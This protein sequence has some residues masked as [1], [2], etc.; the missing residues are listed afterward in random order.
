MRIIGVDFSGAGT[1]NHVGNTWLAQGR[2]EG[3]TLT[4]ESC[5][6]I[7]RLA[8]T[9]ELAGLT[10]PAVVGMDFPFSVPV[11]FA[12]HW[13]REIDTDFGTMPDLWAAA[14]GIGK[15]RKFKKMRKRFTKD[16]KAGEKEPKRPCD[17]SEGISPLNIRMRAMTLAG[18]QMLHRLWHRYEAG[19]INRPL[20]ILP[21]HPDPEPDSI[22]LLE[23]MPGASVRSLVGEAHRT[24]YKGKG[25]WSQWRL[26]ILDELPEQV[27]KWGLR[28]SGVSER[29]ELCLGNDDAMDAI[30]AAVT[31]ALWKIRVPAEKDSSKCPRASLVG[32]MYVPQQANQ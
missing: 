4:I 27:W 31:A 21:L 11:E 10:E 28:L 23:V 15:L 8:L 7:S 22:T 13:Q 24:G 25:D 17:P 20:R 12:D 9:N 18:M 19:E 6:P 5:R 16:R 30:V 26:E 32:W 3:N 29:T 2:L 1:D 14:D